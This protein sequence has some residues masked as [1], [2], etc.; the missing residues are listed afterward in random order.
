MHDTGFSC[1]CGQSECARLQE[2]NECFK[3]TENDARLAAEFGQ[4]LLQEQDS[5]L[6]YNLVKDNYHELKQLRWENKQSNE[7]IQMLTLNTL[8]LKKQMQEYKE[9]N[10]VCERLLSVKTKSEENLKTQISDLKQELS[11][12]RKA[13]NNMT[14][15]YKRLH[16]GHETLKLTHEA[17]VQ[18]HDGFLLRQRSKTPPPP[19]I[20]PSPSP[21]PPQAPPAAAAA[22]AP[23]QIMQSKVIPQPH[24]TVTDPFQSL[25]AVTQQ[26]LDKINATDTRVLNRRLKRV[27]DMSELSDL[28]NSILSHISNDL[29]D[30]QDQFDWVDEKDNHFFPLVMVIEA[31]YTTYALCV[32]PTATF[33][34]ARK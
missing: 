10:K 2:F 18:E 34:K 26:T 19:F 23:V 11:Q 32:S 17:L 29:K 4:A 27:F 20:S 14:S 8:E 22:A 1:C 7:M 21:P 15:K 24:V 16:Q 31:H 33:I 30:F 6:Q 25:H 3:K 28:S 9:K 12:L 5:E 13:E